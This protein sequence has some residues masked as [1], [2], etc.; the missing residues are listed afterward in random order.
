MTRRGGQ[1][2]NSNA[3]KHG[4]YSRSF[5]ASE[6][7]DLLQVDPNNLDDEI[8]MLKVVARRVLELSEGEAEYDNVLKTLSTLGMTSTRI[9]QL[10]R[11]KKILTG[12]DQ[13]TALAISQALNEV[14]KEL[15]IK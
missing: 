12:E 15:Q 10:M 6:S 8:R 11:T 2:G 13:N 1:P 5:R 9:A 14:I 4:F 3:L 7:A